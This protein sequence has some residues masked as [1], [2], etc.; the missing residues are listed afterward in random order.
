[1]LSFLFGKTR[2]KLPKIES[3]AKT[4]PWLGI[5]ARV[6]DPN[7]N[8]F[9]S[10][11]EAGEPYLCASWE[12]DAMDGVSQAS[13]DK[14]KA[15]LSIFLPGGS[16][17]QVGT[18][19]IPNIEPYVSAYLTNKTNISDPVLAELVRQRY[20]LLLESQE[21]P[22]IE[23]NGIL[24]M[25]RRVFVTLSVPVRGA[26]NEHDIQTVSEAAERLQTTMRTAGLYVN[27]MGAGAYLAMMRMVT[28]PFSKREEWY[29][30]SRLLNEQIFQPGDGYTVERS[31]LHFTD[32][33]TEWYAK[34]LSVKFFPPQAN[35]G[36]MNQ[37]IGDPSGMVDQFT[38]P[39]W[40]VLTLHYPDRV[41]KKADLER[42]FALITHQAFGSMVNLVPLLKHKKHG[43]DV[44]MDALATGSGVVVETNFTI[45][46][47]HPEL[48]ALKNQAGALTSYFS[49]VGFDIKEDAL[50]CDHLWKMSLPGG[51][52]T[53]G[54]KQMHRYHTMTIPQAMCF[55]PVI[56]EW[57]G[58][59][60]SGTMM[61][62][63]RRGFPILFD[64][65][66]ANSFNAT[67]FAE[68][69]AGKSFFTQS[70]I[71]DYLAEGAK[72]W[73]I[74]VGNSYKK[75]SAAVD[76]EFI[77][78]EDDSG[79]CLNPFT[80]VLDI[81][82]DTDLIKAMLAKM[83]AP[84]EGL[85]DFRM[86]VLEEAIKSTWARYGNSSSVTA[87]SEWCLS[88]PD[89]RI[90]DIGKQLYPFTRFGSFGRWFDGD[91]N[92]EMNRDFVVLE[93]EELKSRP[94]LQ[95]VILIQ[96]MATISHEMYKSGEARRKIFILD[97]A[98]SLLDDP[99]MGKAIEGLYRKSR[100][101]KGS[102]VIVT[103]ALSDIYNSPNG[104]AINQ[105][106][107]WQ[108]ILQQKPESIDDALA[109]GKFKLDP[110]GTRML[111]MVHTSHGHYSELMIRQAS[112]AYG[113]ARLVMDRFTQVLF[114]T[115][116]AE[117]DDIFAA[118]ERGE[119][120]VDAI[121]NFIER[122]N[123]NGLRT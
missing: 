118:M 120:V 11:S 92:L 16:L 81:D 103:Q 2:V 78:F 91:N 5:G 82:D 77:S 6:F 57:K 30:E 51:P 38:H 47:Y 15:A 107:Q 49:T 87:V 70:L 75:L 54:I 52:T 68:T 111:K 80:N 64:L 18:F 95:K 85:D 86:A 4:A 42:R 104:D 56:G 36:I 39:Y 88:Q 93:L 58:S 61:F 94:I 13:V 45:W 66:E 14:F 79:I 40:M 37:M 28:H 97:E 98:W 10:V 1:M 41:A 12:A 84:E 59:G 24:A 122:E 31:H 105:N 102:V 53:M 3:W 71:A 114:S 90:Q 108:I 29:D 69:G 74:D 96:L 19:T 67:V 89:P 113:V 65:Y 99:V 73:T 119:N 44:M 121:H 21:K 20:K 35:L 110:Y 123:H 33:D 83:A 23:S 101:Y 55:L 17:V 32:A 112:G 60:N 63:S 43:F 117:R 26:S 72:V 115:K 48:Q 34:P 25:V 9:Y 62:S 22:L 27:R 50:I 116:G 7:T 100:K 109:S 76:G 46:L 8:L 106:S